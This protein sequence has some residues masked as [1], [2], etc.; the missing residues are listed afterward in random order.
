MKLTELLI[1]FWLQEGRIKALY[2]GVFP[3]LLGMIPYAGM[4]CFALHVHLVQG[5]SYME[6]SIDIE[7]INLTIQE[8][9]TQVLS[10]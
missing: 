6:T 9:V 5:I 8:I 2:R 1:Y 4:I 3:T 7:Y 10:N